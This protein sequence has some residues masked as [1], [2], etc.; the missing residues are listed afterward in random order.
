MPGFIR[1]NL[2]VVLPLL[3]AHLAAMLQFPTYRV[4]I[5]KH[6]GPLR[7]ASLQADQYVV[8]RPEDEAYNRRQIQ[9]A[10]RQDGRVDRG[11]SVV[12]WSRLNLDYH[13][14]DY[15]WLLN[16]DYGEMDFENA[17]RNA[18]LTWIPTDSNNNVVAIPTRIL[19]LTAAVTDVADW[20]HAEFRLNYQMYVD[21]NQG[22]IFP[23]ATR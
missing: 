11:V 9:S 21:V 4:V 19:N 13:A 5:Q 22:N 7:I 12:C 6:G 16:P 2:G 15:S 3:Q 10:G 17:V 23:G 8:L 18:V 20:G 1:S 14:Q